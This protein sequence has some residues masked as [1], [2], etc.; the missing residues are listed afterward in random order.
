M[1]ASVLSGYIGA[2]AA[3]WLNRRAP[4][5]A[6]RL[7]AALPLALFLYF[8]GRLL[9]GGETAE[10]W[11]WAPSLGVNLSFQLDGLSILFALL[12]TGMGSVVLFYSS[13]YLEDHRYLGRLYGYLLAFMASMLGLVLSANLVLIYLFW[14]L[15]S[16]FSYLLIGFENRQEAA[17]KSALQAL[18]VT[19]AGGLSLLAGILLLGHMGGS[20][21]IS[22][23]M[24][25]SA[26]LRDHPLYLP[27]LLLIL[28]GAFTKSAQVPFHFWL[29]SAMAAPTPVS[30]YLHSA[31]MV[32]A[33]LYLLARLM[34]ILGG[35]EAWHYAITT[36]GV[37][38]MLTGAIMAFPQ[39][40]LKRLLAYS[41][42][43]ALGTL[44]LLIGIGTTTAVEAFVVYL[45]VHVLYKGA[46]FLVAGAV[47]HSTGTRTLH[48]L[49]GLWKVMPAVTVAAALAALS[50]AGLPPMLGFIGKELLYEAK[51]QAPRAAFFITGAGVLANTFMVAVAFMVGF[52]PFFGDAA[53]LP[54][55]PHGASW[56][57][58]LGPLILA[59]LG[60]GIG[61]FPDAAAQVLVAP[62]VSAIR[63][64]P[65]EVHLKLW[66]G[67]NQVLLL[68]IAT[69]AG[70]VLLYGAR[71]IL[72]QRAAGRPEWNI[73]GPARFYQIL[74][75]GMLGLAGI[76][77]RLLQSG[78][79]RRYLMAA[80]GTAI[81][82]LAFA[83]L[84]QGEPLQTGWTAG[85]RMYELLTAGVVMAGALTAAVTTSRLAAVAAL[86]AVGYGVALIYLLFG[87]PD[88][89]MTQ[90]CIETLTVILFVLVL[91][92]L[93]RF[94]LL[95]SA[96]V[97][98]R[99]ALVALACGVMM[100]L[101]TLTAL[102]R[103]LQSRV[104][105]FYAE[106]SLPEAH[107][108]NVVNV[109]IVDFRALDTLGEITVFAVAAIGIYGLIKFGSRERG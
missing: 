79:L 94:S 88:L 19:G 63:A 24:E 86:G 93:P 92:R 72:L 6:G 87:A 59:L 20:L 52:R 48:Q 77:T 40:D 98:L 18:L 84:R 64:E 44:M 70:G 107:G 28:A 95:S 13:D 109:I 31:T 67:V 4:R 78:Y 33:G 23:L 108:R 56:R 49:G 2:L 7:C 37:A 101:L 58:W 71:G 80:V 85:V 50:M 81:L 104:S 69:V 25:R 1:L 12:I 97:R 16:I 73:W 8:A 102:S 29:P 47:D 41:T 17:R 105:G 11:E 21:E 54:R 26:D 32:K 68:G 45:L 90:F 96:S 38:T 60:T 39:E 51:L 62:A 65:S 100:T 46:L 27:A 61:L 34:P 14:E 10:A 15:T 9:P 53:D 22:H 74:L 76:Q 57:L 3:P 91:Y 30:A 103:P 36:A 83:L 66:H 99:D 106:N 35:S 89:A 43:S 82:L 55:K 5:H 42:V 75:D